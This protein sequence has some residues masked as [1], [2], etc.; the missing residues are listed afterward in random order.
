MLS[1]VSS[2]FRT[3]GL[4]I[5]A[6]QPPWVGDGLVDDD[7][8]AKAQGIDYEI[9][10]NGGFWACSIPII[11]PIPVIEDW[12]EHGLGRDIKVRDE[13]AGLV[14]NGFVNE[15]SAGISVLSARRGPMVEVANRVRVAYST[16]HYDTIPPVGG[17]EAI[18]DWTE[19][20]DS[21]QRYGIQEEIIEGGERTAAQADQLAAVYLADRAWPETT[22]DLDLSS[23]NQAI[24]RL[25]CRGYVDFL[26][27]HIYN[28]TGV[29]GTVVT[30]EKIRAVLQANPNSLFTDLSMIDQNGENGYEVNQYEND[31]RTAKAIIDEIVADGGSSDSG[32]WTFGIY[33]DRRPVYAPVPSTIAYYQRLRDSSLQLQA[34]DSTSIPHWNIRPAR[35][36]QISDF[37]AG[38]SRETAAFG[39][40]LRRDPRNLFAESV[41]FSSPWSLHVAGGRVNRID[42]ELARVR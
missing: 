42:Q 26:D 33:D 20:E 24:A 40:S 31:N 30:A 36:V 41:R 3:T 13:V 6:S 39:I 1:P 11:A 23:N 14:W 9:V 4:A 5:I 17:Q 19:D 38:R 10:A 27:R 28:L 29:S 34:P 15:V 2:H 35:W 7:L 18:T 12:F 22:N 25:D 8:A 16:V 32:R 21:Q 37:L